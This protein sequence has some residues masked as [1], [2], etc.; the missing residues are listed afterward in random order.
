MARVFNKRALKY[1]NA[2]VNLSHC[3]FQNRHKS[4]KIF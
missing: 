4:F 1:I 3:I 2:V